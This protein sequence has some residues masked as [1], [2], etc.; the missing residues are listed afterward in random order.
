MTGP[1][2]VVSTDFVARDVYS[3]RIKGMESSTRR[4]AASARA[5][6]RSVGA[7]FRGS[8]LGT[9]TS[10]IV[11]SGLSRISSALKSAVGD[12]VRF[13]TSLSR[14][15]IR[16][17]EGAERG[18][19]AFA[20]LE[21]G[22]RDLGRTGEA[23]SEQ[24]A[25]AY[26]SLAA[27]GFNVKQSVSAL[28]PIMHLS[29]ATNTEFA[30]AANIAAK[31]LR[32]FNLTTADASKVSDIYASVHKRAGTSV[33]DLYGAVESGGAAFAAS[34][35][36]LETY[37]SLIGALN[38]RG[39]PASRAAMALS[40]A[41]LRV[42]GG[43]KPA[44]AALKRLGIATTELGTD[45][46]KH[47]R[48]FLDIVGD[49]NK[50]LAGKGEKDRAKALSG[51]FDTRALKVLGPL[52]NDTTGEIRAFADATKNATGLAEKM[53]TELD[54]GI[55]D[56]LERIKT[57]LAERGLDIVGGL[58]GGA[59]N[60]D[61]ILAK[62][63]RFDVTP[64]VTG[65]K[66]VGKVLAFMADH[67]EGI[68]SVAKSLVIIKGAMMLKGGVQMGFGLA[69][70]V[71]GMAGN[72]PRLAA[73][74]AGMGGG[75]SP[76]RSAA[77]TSYTAAGM[78]PAKMTAT[79]G[80][81]MIVTPGTGWPMTPPS[82]EK[83]KPAG[84]G[85][86]AGFS[87]AIQAAGIGVAIGMAASEAMQRA[88]DE[89]VTRQNQDLARYEAARK[90]IDKGD[91]AGAEKF[92]RNAPQYEAGR[93]EGLGGKMEMGGAFLGSV[94]TGGANPLEEAQANTKRRQLVATEIATAFTNASTKSSE[95]MLAL[96][97]TFEDGVKLEI[98]VTDGKVTGAK[99]KSKKGA[100][101]APSVPVSKAGSQR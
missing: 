89:T 32:A 55:G 20:E 41:V 2:Y 88:A 51:I 97:K 72:A 91:Y 76:Q 46:K 12:Y 66:A 43:S 23:T 30:S 3:Q 26:G 70:A 64:I 63:N 81:K 14:A 101:S 56:K 40:Q 92:L 50:K 10:N 6:F 15:A 4:F 17:P 24:A 59:G 87:G 62:I 39:I 94:F 19:K 69:G 8:F 96:K 78:T 60:I 99:T 93:Y 90:M 65:M 77:F 31:S 16:F 13:D 25:L 5:D 100:P 28:T 45:G 22:A 34:G 44:S 11:T 53:D 82:A 54:K 37:L 74:A 33:E 9:F 84:I 52:F 71:G 1:T 49:L 75:M 80:G 18:S 35:Q 29:E 85:M 67:A 36:S 21:R 68:L 86:A 95:M 61:A 7:V 47:V 27:A 73:A 98:E 58:F 79:G 57:A 38:Q 48:G 83:M 42:S